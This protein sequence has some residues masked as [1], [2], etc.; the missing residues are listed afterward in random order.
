[1]ELVYTARMKLLKKTG[2]EYKKSWSFEFVS[3]HKQPHLMPTHKTNDKHLWLRFK[4]HQEKAFK[5]LKW[6]TFAFRQ[7]IK[8]F[9]LPM[10]LLLFPGVYT[11]NC[12]FL[13]LQMLSSIKEQFIMTWT[14]VLRPKNAC[15]C[16]FNLSEKLFFM[17][18]E[19][20]VLRYQRQQLLEKK[21][22]DTSKHNF[23]VMNHN[24]QN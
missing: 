20:I 12:S 11:A 10:L 23:P 8:T 4:K 2:S 7:M 13:A 19:E 15:H 6:K 3:C 24:A 18:E 1:M 22:Q 16:L 9:K 14:R 21:I 17:D 5:Q